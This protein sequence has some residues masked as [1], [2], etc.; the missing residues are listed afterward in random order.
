MATRAPF[1]QKNRGGAARPNRLERLLYILDLHVGEPE[2]ARVGDGTLDEVGARVPAYVEHD[3]R[4]AVPW[5]LA[6]VR[7]Q[8]LDA[9]E[10]VG[11][12]C[13]LVGRP[14]VG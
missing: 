1:G 10:G 2:R 12:R 6:H 4:V 3:V 8:E 5:G 14:T 11:H 7:R 9:H 13:L